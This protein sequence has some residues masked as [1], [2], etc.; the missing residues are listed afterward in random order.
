MQEDL[1]IL[2]DVKTS[3]KLGIELPMGILQIAK[4]VESEKK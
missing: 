2:V 3:R 4:S 1:K